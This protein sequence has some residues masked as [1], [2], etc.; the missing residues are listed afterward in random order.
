MANPTLTYTQLAERNVSFQLLRT[1]PK[2][3]T[4]LKLTIDSGGDLWFNSI[5]ANKQLT[6]QQYKRF[7]INENSSHEVNLYK[8]Y[9]NGKTPS[10][11]AYEAG[12]TIGKTAVAKDLKDQYDFDLYTSGA[13][14]LSSRQYSEKF[15]YLAPLY[16]DQV[17][18]NKFVIFKVPGPSN[19]TAGQGKDLDG[20]IKPEEFATDLFKN[21]TI[22][23][24]FDMSPTSKIGKY[25]E[26]IRK[27]PMF[28]K[29]PLY[30]NYK[31]DGFS[32]YRGPSIKTGT[33]VEL[34]EQLSTVL[35]RALPLLKV[36]QFVTQG[37][38]RNNVIHPKILNLEFLFND[39]TSNPYEFNRYFGFYCNDIDLETIDI[40]LD[41]MFNTKVE[42]LDS[43]D[44]S[45]Y[46]SNSVISGGIVKTLTV[47]PA[48]D[49]IYIGG[50]FT[51]YNGYPANGIIRLNPTGEIDF[52]FNS[53]TGFSPAKVESIELDKFGKLYVGGEMLSYN[54]TPIS[55]FIKLNTDGS[56]DS[57]DFSFDSS[58]STIHITN[59]QEIYVGGTFTE[60]INSGDVLPAVG[61]VKIGLDGVADT[62]FDVGSTGFNAGSSITNVK[63]VITNSSNKVIVIGAFTSYQGTSA[64][65]IVQLTN[66][67]AIDSTF[68]YGTGFNNLASIN[69]IVLDE[70]GSVYVAGGF[71]SYNSN[72]VNRLIKLT[73]TGSID[74]S[75][76]YQTGAND[77]ISKITIDLNG[78]FYIGGKFTSYKS[79]PANGLARIFKDGEL[80]FSFNTSTGFN[81]RTVTD[82][83][84]HDESHIY[85]TGGFTKFQEIPTGGLL[86][87]ANVGTDNDQIL[88]IRY[89]NS[90]DISFLLT[91]PTGVK[92]RAMNLTQ[93]LSDLT[94]NRTSKDTLFF[95][96][97]KTKEG[98]LH[99]INSEDWNQSGNTV[100]FKIDDTSFDL[101]LTF[102]PNEL[103]TQ[104]TAI[105]STLD[106]KS[107]VSIEVV[108]KPTHLDTI[109]IYHPSGSVL[110]PLDQ[111]GKYDELVFTRGY[112]PL[113][114]PYTLAYSAGVS[115]IYINGDIDLDLI[116]KAISD[117]S[118]QLQ[119]TSISGVTLNTTAF[120]QS[121]RYGDA[122]GEL[123]VKVI[124]VLSN[125]I[126]VKLNNSVTT[127][128]V[129]ADGGFLNKSHAIID[130]GNI[131]KLTP[132]LNDL[133]IKTDQNWST[134]SRL[135]NVT[136]LIKNGLSESDRALAISN[137]NNKATIQLTDDESVNVKYGKIEIRKVFKPKVGVLSI[138]ETMD[139][140]FSTYSSD[141]SRNLFLDLYKDFYIP[142]GAKVLDFTKYTY[143]AIGAGSI[144]INGTVYDPTDLAASGERNLIWQ[145]TPDISYFENIDGDVILAYGN[146]LPLTTLDPLNT[147][148]SDRLD[149]PYFDESDDALDYIG[150]FSLKADHSTASLS[151]VTYPYREKFVSGNLSSE[152]HAYLENF[153]PDFATDGRVI[154]YINKWGIADSSDSR[155]NPYRLNSDILFGKDNF[156]P[157][158]RDTSP[159]PEKMTH[160]W[161]YIESD[162]GYTGD[163]KSIRSNYSYFNESLEIEQLISDQTYF[164]KYFTYVPSVDSTQIARPQYRYSILNKNQFN[165]Q[166]E[167]LFKGAML[168]FYELAQDGSTIANTTRFED[169]KFSIL[170][171]PVKEDAN[172]N[173][174]PIKYR[175]IEN[176]NS[177]SITIV[178]EL[179]IGHKDQISP[180]V[181]NSEW[182][183]AANAGLAISFV[184]TSSINV[185]LVNDTLI[186]NSV[187]HKFTTGQRVKHVL[188]G[189][190]AVG[191][192]TNLTKYYVIVVDANSFKLC[193]TLADVF[194]N[195]PI[196]LTS[197]GTGGSIFTPV[198]DVFNQ[199]NLFTGALLD[200]P[201][202]YKI[203]QTI[204]ASSLTNYNSLISGATVISANLGETIRVVYGN[205]ST[206]LATL[207]SDVYASVRNST[208]ETG[209]KLGP[210]VFVKVDQSS[211]I[212]LTSGVYIGV[213]LQA[214]F[215]DSWIYDTSSASAGTFQVDDDPVGSTVTQLLL[216]SVSSN[217][218]Q[219][220]DG[221]Y[222]FN[223][224]GSINQSVILDQLLPALPRV[225]LAYDRGATYQECVFDVTVLNSSSGGV[226]DM[227]V[228]YVSGPSLGAGYGE[229]ILIK[230][231]W[232]VPV[233]NEE[234]SVIHKVP[235]LDSAIGDYR[236]SFN[237]NNVSNL[238]HSFLYYAKDKKYNSK[239]TAYSTIKLSRGVDLS[240]NGLQLNPTTLVAERIQTSLLPGLESYDS[241]A[242][243][244][245]NRISNDFSPIYVTKPGTRGVLLKINTLSITTPV[246]SDSAVT[247]D[248]V[249]GALQD[250]V[251]ITNSSWPMYTI[252]PL[253]TGIG[254]LNRYSYLAN[255]VPNETSAYWLEEV[256]HF[257]IFGGSKYFEKV[258][259]NLSFAKFSQLTEKSQGVIS[260][261]SYTDG[262]LNPYK[263]MSIEVVTADEITKSTIVKID[264][265]EVNSGQIH[266]IA[267]FSYSEV[268]SHEYAVNRY[269]AEY[270][271]ITKPVAGFKY[272]FS[273]NGNDLTGANICLNPYVDNFFIIKDY[274]FVK[275]SNSSILE[276]ENSQKYSSTYPYISETPI[277]RSDFSM[278]A[279]SWDY[280]YHFDYSNK[281]DYVKIP[282][283]RRITEDYSFISK[284]LNVPTEFTIEEFTSIELNN[285][286]FLA[287]SA[288]QANIV[289][290]QFATEV[291]FKL[292]ISDLITKH[293]SNNGLRDQFLKFFKYSDGSPIITDQLFLGQ[294]TFEQYLSQYCSTNL[295]KLYQV[296]SFEF[297]ELDDRTIE[298]NLVSF[299]EVQYDLLGDLGYNL[300]R[301]VRIN[302]TK[303]N[304][305]EGSIL[306][307]PNTGVKLVPKI[308][309]KFI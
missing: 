274:E 48:T 215:E 254:D 111:N 167:T 223:D 260:W 15:T 269:S 57:T 67:A 298:N 35:T 120:L 1:N 147:T 45:T 296:G 279:S 253:P 139:F 151:S 257:Q 245:I 246:L 8:F 72:A 117:I 229:Q 144:S 281:T 38:E 303:S 171:K 107:T 71:T 96:Y 153:I 5:D 33:Y 200:N 70:V 217:A 236:I 13:K 291:K 61:L 60:Y 302:N 17:V 258:F 271:V 212:A 233:E 203:D 199:L 297:Y 240:A 273:I 83:V 84:V 81:I 209:D 194:N 106:S 73:D 226:Y 29:N 134:I 185:D 158:H 168:R 30:V 208:I 76:N 242:D 156:G 55:N 74:N 295:S 256:N 252:I 34:P 27:N 183:L 262:V 64:N 293:L 154:P 112:L 137:F 207:G 58:V 6:S 230:S 250:V 263:T 266:G 14:Y 23:K 22:V 195:N 231:D 79:V 225:T 280:G 125:S 275:Y 90:D 10:T 85:V 130:I 9:N 265:I 282:G 216:A 292:N 287:S 149:I 142:A 66:T 192:L 91:N 105:L 268:P 184:T 177:K 145:N 175:V 95:P 248:G 121:N 12:S 218:G 307:K 278:L 160:E 16:L 141:Y 53:G 276:L 228:T 161:F 115:T 11:I 39:D 204:Y 51:S 152:Y 238:T 42:T 132:S 75:F 205:Y 247:I 102:G 259:E 178:I 104:E 100:T 255:V 222:Q 232:S 110:D 87:L 128:V 285:Q 101:G 19:Y 52:T 235:Y 77:A 157:S 277:D 59:S 143:K 234:F 190:T 99:L 4:N 136:D 140:N 80:D 239:K 179:A 308:K 41:A 211:T 241:L 54:G 227:D 94:Y 7:S 288:T 159:T 283:T 124:P 165:K 2:L 32:L 196:N 122:Y 114:T 56:I 251:N 133:V 188:A 68:V 210:R 123:K 3:T 162:F 264:P 21:A 270:E 294:L 163:V 306:I 174:Q 284:L 31:K 65:G 62:S 267:G 304:V 155:D 103:V 272:N 186:S 309:I 198:D 119:N 300:I 28:T 172:I 305:I 97:L 299:E 201:V 176:T 244:E 173:R 237:E 129:Y 181:F 88:P 24:V 36:E 206:I 146:K 126:F 191:G 18:P 213:K 131:S 127:S 261:E 98:Q 166:Y 82:I 193:N 113:S 289:Y 109:R 150:P 164:E 78:N 93:D 169:Y 170:L 290:S 243:S 43:I 116:A 182:S 86:N 202:T 138:F 63:K 187:P 92:L 108:S 69:D 46:L 118:D 148:F 221:Y 47:D 286:D 214:F 40:D 219:D 180:A 50:T 26:N 25:L 249:D 44:S 224:A 189:G 135:C 20:N 220:V 197:Y 301:S 49:K 89:K 37:F